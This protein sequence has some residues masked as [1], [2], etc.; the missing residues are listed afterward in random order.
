M[1]ALLDAFDELLDAQEEALG[2]RVKATVGT[3]AVA[4]DCIPTSDN[5]DLFQLD[6]GSG[7]SGGYSLQMRKSDFNGVPTKGTPITISCYP[8]ESL[9]LAADPNEAGGIYTLSVGDLAQTG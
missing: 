7:I 9:E 4:M 8:D 6:G 2:V 5:S 3:F 1:S